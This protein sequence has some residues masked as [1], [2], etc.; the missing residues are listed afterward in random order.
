MQMAVPDL[1]SQYPPKVA[2]QCGLRYDFFAYGSLAK[3][4][5]SAPGW[6]L[7]TAD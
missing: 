4:V 7:R 2:G 1:M 5:P 6:D 3:C